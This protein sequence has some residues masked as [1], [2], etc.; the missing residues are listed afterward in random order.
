[1]SPLIVLAR[2][3]TS[4]PSDATGA[5]PSASSDDVSP[6]IDDASTCTVEPTRIPTTTSPDAERIDTSP[7][8]TEPISTSPDAVLT[9]AP[10]A[11]S[12]ILTSPDADRTVDLPETVPSSTSPDALL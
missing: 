5:S 6:L 3:S 12:R 8:V 11:D 2:R 10:P 1:M 7:S 9:E 4:G